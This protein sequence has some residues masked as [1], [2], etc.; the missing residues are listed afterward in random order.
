MQEKLKENKN[1]SIEKKDP[2]EKN[3][4]PWLSWEFKAGLGYI[5]E[6][7]SQIGE[8]ANDSDTTGLSL[9]QVLPPQ[10]TF[11]TMTLVC[12]SFPLTIR[13]NT[14]GIIL[15][16]AKLSSPNFPS[17]LLEKYSYEK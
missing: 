15:T 7:L 17:I 1:K 11:N 10:A 12:F 5:K 13:K 2:K 9:H 3:Q 6:T 4:D 8:S 16:F 14:L